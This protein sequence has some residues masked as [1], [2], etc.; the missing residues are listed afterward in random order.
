[1]KTHLKI[2][3]KT[4]DVIPDLIFFQNNLTT[5]QARMFPNYLLL[6]GHLGIYIRDTKMFGG[7]G[8]Y[9]F[10]KEAEKIFNLKS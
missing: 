9:G 6:N 8:S 2:L 5:N 10:L 1:M 7:G 4:R 3:L